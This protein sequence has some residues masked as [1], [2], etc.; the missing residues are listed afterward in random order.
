MKSHYFSNEKKKEIAFLLPT[1]SHVLIYFAH[2]LSEA[3]E[4]NQNI[5]KTRERK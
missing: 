5:A 1:F 4:K 2:I 3:L